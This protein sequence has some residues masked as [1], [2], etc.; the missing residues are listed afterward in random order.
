MW[1]LREGQ[2]CVTWYLARP[3]MA[4]VAPLSAPPSDDRASAR[5]PSPW[6]LAGSAEYD[7]VPKKWRD[8]LASRLESELHQHVVK[9]W[10]PRCIDRDGGG[11]LCDFDARWRADGPQNR[12]LEFQARQTRTAARL[13]TAYPSES[14]WPEV[15]L[16]GIAYL[17]DVMNDKQYG[18][19]FWMLDSSGAPLAD[20]T[21]HAHSTAY[22][23]AAAVD[24]FR[25]TGA[26]DARD[27]A[28]AAFD[29][30]ERSVHDAEHGG[31]MGWTGRDGRP[32]SDRSKSGEP[33][34]HTAGLKDSNVHSDL[35]DAF[36][37]L[38]EVLPQPLVHERLAE[39][40][41]ILTTSFATPAGSMHYLTYP[42]LT[43]VPGIER[44]GY[45]LQTAFRLPPAAMAIGIPVEAALSTAR[46]LVNHATA[47]GWDDARGGLIEA[48]P[49]AAPYVLSGTSLRVTIRP[50]WVQTEALKS[51]LLLALTDP[52][53]EYRELFARELEVVDREYLD[54]RLGGWLA[55]ARS[56]MHGLGRRLGRGIRKGDI[57]KDA[58][59]E[60]DFYLSSTRMLRGIHPSGSL[61]SA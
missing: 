41:R 11:F 22:V 34:G 40:Y 49:G 30:L 24:V 4:Q 20:Q 54:R 51:Y 42:D 45:P 56:D 25:L 61:E 48:G 29:W 7:V 13:G 9:P 58:S 32:I 38:D 12:M 50:W 21:K 18:G 35:L 46:Q 6:P 52:A 33:L 47:H 55:V 3:P 19:W 31:Y 16:H 37:I 8:Q 15:A 10:F 1:R 53:S 36:T 23:L 5:Q 39:V 28:L 59:H 2:P 60:T 57:W 43:P 44:F 14:S 26:A 17:R 27:M